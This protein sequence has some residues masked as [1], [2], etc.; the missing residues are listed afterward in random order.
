MLAPPATDNPKTATI[1]PS[2]SGIAPVYILNHGILGATGIT[3]SFPGIR[4]RTLKRRY[5]Y[6]PTDYLTALPLTFK[7]SSCDFITIGQIGGQPQNVILADVDFLLSSNLHYAI[8]WAP[9]PDAPNETRRLWH[10]AF[11]NQI[12]DTIL[13]QAM[14]YLLTSS[15]LTGVPHSL[16]LFGFD[17]QTRKQL[18]RS[19]IHDIFALLNW[20]VNNAPNRNYVVLADGTNLSYQ[21]QMRLVAELCSHA[22]WQMLT[23]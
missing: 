17:Y 3:Q 21:E 20:L 5:V 22:A 11:L 18:N 14:R 13:L 2:D 6:L 23:N 9:T 15:W 10:T 16:R 12:S 19:G 7:I 1:T 4:P 8:L